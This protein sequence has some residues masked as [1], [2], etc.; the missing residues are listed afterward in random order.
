MTSINITDRP[1]SSR[2]RTPNKFAKNK[3][4]KVAKAETKIRKHIFKKN[5]KLPK[6][7]DAKRKCFHCHEQGYQKKNCPKYLKRLKAKKDQGNVPL[8][9]IHVL[10]LNYVDNSDDSWKIDS[11]ATNHVCSS[12]QLLTKA[13][14]LRAKEFTLRVGNRESVS[15]DAVGEVRLQFG[16][17]FLLLDNVYFIPNISRNL[18]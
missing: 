16:N 5:G 11:G 4:G 15:A 8:H 17:K 7:K 2:N 18:I 3:G 9:F 6:L 10:E 13:R 14:K 12:L 1:R